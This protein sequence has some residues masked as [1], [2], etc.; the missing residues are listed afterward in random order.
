MWGGYC[1][2]ILFCAISSVPPPNPVET[3]NA[4]HVQCQKDALPTGHARARRA[5]RYTSGE[6]NKPDVNP[7]NGAAWWGRAGQAGSRLELQ[8]DNALFSKHSGGRASGSGYLKHLAPFIS[9]PWKWIRLLSA[10]AN[11]VI[12]FL[13]APFAFQQK[14]GWTKVGRS[15]WSCSFFQ[16]KLIPQ[17]IWRL[18]FINFFFSW[19]RH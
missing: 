2:Y 7:R 6:Q 8:A 17:R 16:L 14:S 1:V 10:R 11:E 15:S 19:K 5:R 12:W 3:R 18:G 13:R 4:A 9:P